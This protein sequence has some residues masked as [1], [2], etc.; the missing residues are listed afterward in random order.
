MIH[1]VI[2]RCPFCPSIRSQ[3]DGIA[4]NLE[5]DLGISVSIEDGD[6]DELSVFVDG[7]PVIQRIG[8]NLQTSDEV[9]AAV[10]N[11]ISSSV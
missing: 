5:T 10:R 1:I 3:V 4:K 2:K 7:V 6:R 9:E 11:A 8:D